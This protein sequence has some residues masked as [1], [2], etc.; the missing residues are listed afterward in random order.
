M[1]IQPFHHRI[2]FSFYLIIGYFIQ[3]VTEF[4]N[5]VWILQMEE[6]KNAG[7]ADIG[8]INNLKQNAPEPFRKNIRL[9]RFYLNI[10]MERGEKDA[11]AWQW[12][13]AF[14]VAIW[15]NKRT[16][17]RDLDMP[18]SIKW[19]KLTR[20]LREL[21]YCSKYSCFTQPGSILNGQNAEWKNGT[22]LRTSNIIAFDG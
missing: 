14:S 20:E 16:H 19:I 3:Q 8:N 4:Y 17:I 9:W 18:I 1:L 5:W 7:N 21:Y 22:D 10:P 11:F 12:A 2:Y 6:Q 15:I 13:D